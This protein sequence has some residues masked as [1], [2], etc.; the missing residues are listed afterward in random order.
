MVIRARVLMGTRVSV[1]DSSLM[2][3]MTSSASRLGLVYMIEFN[4]K[5]SQNVFTK[6]L[7]LGSSGL[8][9]RVNLSCT[10]NGR[11][12]CCQLAGVRAGWSVKARAHL[13][14]AVH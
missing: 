11:V 7:N 8:T 1:K 12:R 6:Y 13:P 2:L 4:Y 5:S 3:L 10:S 14:M 9:P